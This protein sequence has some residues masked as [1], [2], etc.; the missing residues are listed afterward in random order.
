[1]NKNIKYFRKGEQNKKLSSCGQSQFTWNVSKHWY[2][3]HNV[4]LFKKII[5]YSYIIYYLILVIINSLN[6]I[7]SL[8]FRIMLRVIYPGNKII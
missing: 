8:F 6:L 1:M 4:L 3:I 2:M 7:L 5:S